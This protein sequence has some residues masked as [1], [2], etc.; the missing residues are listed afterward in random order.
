MHENDIRINDSIDISPSELS[1]RTSRSGGP[2][3]QNVNKVESK[4]EL[5]FD[6][7]NSVSLPD[8]ERHII[9]NRLGNK[10]D[11]DGILHISSRISRSQL[12]NREIVVSEFI[13]VLR[14]ALK[15]VKKRVPTRPTKTS[16]EKR[17]KKKK[18]TGE[19]KKMRSARII[20]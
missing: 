6:V 8:K 16:R 10:I 17:L 11:S 1:F 19:K 4:V 9:F 2:G 20:D 14:A 12:E 13:R 7:R 5:L 18:I 15:P 3:G